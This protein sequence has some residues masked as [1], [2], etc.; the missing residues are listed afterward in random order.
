VVTRE[1]KVKVRNKWQSLK[2]KDKT[3]V[4]KTKDKTPVLKTKDKYVSKAKLK[5]NSQDP[6][7]GGDQDPTLKTLQ[8]QSRRE[9]V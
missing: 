4:L 8:D 5:T 9:L 1:V 6:D 3:P 2:T 7:Q